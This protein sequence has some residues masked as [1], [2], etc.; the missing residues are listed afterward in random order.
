[1]TSDSDIDMWHCNTTWHW[2]CHV[3]HKGPDT[4]QFFSFQKIKKITDW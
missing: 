2:Q 3:S 1:M 4:W